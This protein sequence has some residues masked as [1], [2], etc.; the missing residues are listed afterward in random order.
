MQVRVKNCWPAVFGFSCERGRWCWEMIDE[1]ETRLWMECWLSPREAAIEKG[2]TAGVV[3]SEMLR[4]QHDRCLQLLTPS[5]S[6]PP[7]SDVNCA[8]N[9]GSGSVARPSQ[10]LHHS[11]IS[12]CSSVFNQNETCIRKIPLIPLLWIQM[13]KV[14]QTDPCGDAAAQIKP[15]WQS[16]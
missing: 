5:T 14:H 2:F 10:V 11:F 9:Y 3:S 13:P 8:S 15:P 7:S 1:L 6:N 12:F 16:S 4:P